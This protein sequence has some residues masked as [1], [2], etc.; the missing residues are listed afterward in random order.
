MYFRVAR[1]GRSVRTLLNKANFINT[2]PKDLKKY[3]IQAADNPRNISSE[4]KRDRLKKFWSCLLLEQSLTTTDLSSA[5]NSSALVSI[6][7]AFKYKQLKKRF[8][9]SSPR[10]SITLFLLK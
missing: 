6:I 3:A 8:K 5:L 10:L 2:E 1:C 9:F 4:P 7:I